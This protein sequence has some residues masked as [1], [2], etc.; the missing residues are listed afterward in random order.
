MSLTLTLYNFSKRRN[1]TKQ[2]TGGTDFDVV[3]K[4]PTSMNHPVFQL[5]VDDPTGFNYAKF[6]GKYY[7]IDD[8]ISD[9]NNVWSIQCSV[10]PLATCKASILATTSYV[11]YRTGGNPDL[12]DSRLAV[13]F[14]TQTVVEDAMYNFISPGIGSYYLAVVGQDSCETFQVSA[15][16]MKSIMNNATQWSTNIIDSSTVESALKTI[17]TQTLSQGSASDCIKAAYWLPV[18]ASVISGSSQVIT[19][20]NFQTN[21]N[22]KVVNDRVITETVS[23]Q[24]PHVYS[25]WR[26]CQ[27]YTMVSLKLPFYGVIDVPSDV[28]AVNSSLS[29]RTQVN[30]L[31]GD[32]THTVRG[33]SENGHFIQCG[34]NIYSPVLI[35][36]SNITAPVAAGGIIATGVAAALGNVPGVLAGVAA[37]LAGVSPVPTA[38]GAIGG[39]SNLNNYAECMVRTRNTSDM[40]GSGN[41]VQ[42]LPYFKTVSLSGIS[43][44]VQCRGF[45]LQASEDSDIIDSVNELM[46]TGVFI[47]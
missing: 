2:P 37:T 15:S 43:G 21:F 46:N 17:F 11:E 41:A 26:K 32:F 47:E 35:G 14:D 9:R 22:G 8:I 44:Y 3:L 39:S 1:S 38:S 13:E 20:G 31:S 42:G 10:D 16:T 4:H 25:D 23:V 28:A 24:I 45:S 18:D 36:A 6:N 29:I 5:A 7:W 33:G 27:P 30:L 19:L 40:P 34:G 12:I